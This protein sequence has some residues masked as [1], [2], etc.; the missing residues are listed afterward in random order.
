V[1]RTKQ[2]ELSEAAGHG[3]IYFSY[4]GFIVSGFSGANLSVAV[5]T[6]AD[7]A[8]IAPL[9]KKLVLKL[10]PELPVDAVK[11]M[12]AL[13]DE[14]LVS[15]RSPALLAGIFAGVALLL[16]AV[17]TYGVLAYAVGQRRREIGVRMALGALPG[18]VLAQFLG[19]GARLLGAGIFL[20]VFGAWAAGRAMQG[21]LFGVGADNMPVFAA[22]AGV[23]TVVV[24]LAVFLPSHR[25]S[26]VSPIEVLRGE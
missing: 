2:N 11:P 19:L 12:Q 25:A 10:D 26:R 6:S 3:A 17:G 1:G 5:R 22:T 24:L 4:L 16:A 13:I 9:I 18:Q 15:R 20:G 21:Q 7:P 23:M 8:A 14:S